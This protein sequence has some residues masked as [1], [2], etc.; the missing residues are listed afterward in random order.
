M[1]S[2]IFI[3]YKK[4]TQRFAESFFLK[5]RGNENN[6]INLSCWFVFLLID[7]HFGVEKWNFRQNDSL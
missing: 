1:I 7:N 6:I 3:I 2:Q 5:F 4:K